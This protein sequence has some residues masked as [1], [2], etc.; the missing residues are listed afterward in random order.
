MDAVFDLTSVRRTWTHE[1]HKSGLVRRVLVGDEVAASPRTSPN[2]KDAAPPQLYLQECGNSTTA[3]AR[4]HRT[5]AWRRA[6]TIDCILDEKPLHFDE[7]KATYPH[8]LHGRCADGSIVYVELLGKLDVSKLPNDADVARHFA[9]IHEW[10]SLRY[11]GENTTLISV[12]DLHGLSWGQLF[13]AK[14]LKLLQAAAHV[15]DNL[16]PYRTRAVLITNAPAWFSIA[17]QIL[18]LPS[19]IRTKVRVVEDFAGIFKTNHLPSLHELQTHPD[20]RALCD[21]VTALDFEERCIGDEDVDDG[22]QDFHSTVSAD[23]D[24][25]YYDARATLTEEESDSDTP[26]DTPRVWWYERLLIYLTS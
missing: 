17:F 24:D 19:T 2:G 10:L 25:F 7:I 22:D 6:H 8:Y 15:Q 14:A 1:V 12:V 16:V 26:H 3:K 11:D 23:T 20:E 4:W 18:P 21:T 13:S 9:F 5:I